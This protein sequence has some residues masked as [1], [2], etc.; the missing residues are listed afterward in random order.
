M[1][2]FYKPGP[3]GLCGNDDCGQMSAWY[4]FSALG[5]Y[6]VDP[7]SGVY[8]L[9]SP[10]VKSALLRLPGGRTLRIDT[11][12]QA[13]GHV[14]VQSVTWNGRS[15]DQAWIQHEALAKGGRLVFTLG[16]APG[17]FAAKAAAPPAFQIP[18]GPAR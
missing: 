12:N 1:S 17:P 16:A 13:E 6:P 18:A 11:R 15:L 4:V 9:G 5:L 10:Q 3:E 7:A 8:I 14:Y 2:T